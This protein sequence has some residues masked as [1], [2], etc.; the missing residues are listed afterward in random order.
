MTVVGIVMTMFSDYDGYYYYYYYYCYYYGNAFPAFGN[1]SDV[2]LFR[3]EMPFIAD[4][5]QV[6][7]IP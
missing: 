2:L 4:C 6:V 7:R 5:L 1:A 3:N